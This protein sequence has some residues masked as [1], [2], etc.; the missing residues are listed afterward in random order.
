[1]RGSKAPT[2]PTLTHR[3]GWSLHL[4]C[5]RDGSEE[6]LTEKLT[7]KQALEYCIGHPLACVR[8]NYVMY[9]GAVN[10]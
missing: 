6:K 8:S 10:V 7:L 4:T 5:E 1:M 2:L 3:D 9:D